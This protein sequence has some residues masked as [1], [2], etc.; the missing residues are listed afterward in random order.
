M[1]IDVMVFALYLNYLHLLSSFCP[2]NPWDKQQAS[3][4]EPF[5]SNQI[6]GSSI[7]VGIRT[8]TLDYDGLIER[9]E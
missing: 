6:N 2:F 4:D 9:I 5:Y 8:S 7:T 1:V 3:I